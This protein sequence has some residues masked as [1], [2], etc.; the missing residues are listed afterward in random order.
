MTYSFDL[1]LIDQAMNQDRAYIV[2]ETAFGVFRVH[3][4]NV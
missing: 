2:D 3:T 4:L 1:T